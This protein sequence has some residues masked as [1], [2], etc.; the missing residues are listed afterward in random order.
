MCYI[1]LD[2][3]G[4]NSD[5]RKIVPLHVAHFFLILL[6]FYNIYESLLATL[7]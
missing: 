6:V 7:G 2:S 4:Y 3:F 5:G 1:Y